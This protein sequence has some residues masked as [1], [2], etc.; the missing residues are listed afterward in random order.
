MS[1]DSLSSDQLIDHPASLA[2]R[3]VALGL[4]NGVAKARERLGPSVDP[5]AV[6][7]FRVA[8]R[9]FRSWERAFR[10]ELQGAIPKKVRKRLRKMAQAANPSRDT[11]VHLEWLQEQLPT[12][13]ASEHT[14]VAWLIGSLEHALGLS[15][16]ALL[17][18][19]DEYFAMMHRRVRRGL[20]SVPVKRIRKGVRL[21]D[22]VA[23]RIVRQGE[24]LQRCLVN[25][26]SSGDWRGVHQAR[27]AG[28]RL[29][30]ILEPLVSYGP[31]MDEIVEQLKRLQDVAGDFH[32]VHVFANDIVAAAQV[33]AAAY[34]KDLTLA[35]V[36]GDVGEAARAQKDNPTPGVL[37]VAARLRERASAG[38]EELRRDWLEGG[39]SGWV[40]EEVRKVAEGV[41]GR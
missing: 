9:R 40:L 18:E 10:L 2:V 15:D 32:D 11:A 20:K 37:A 14:G 1:A 39:K 36:K 17:K 27:I 6:H 25:V 31:E 30:Y 26:Q 35:V 12:V 5:D 21:G 29:R 19:I 24:A 34:A 41:R 8:L 13:T 3:S 22:V 28:K 38:F 7:D 16:A 4:L 23:E 33:G